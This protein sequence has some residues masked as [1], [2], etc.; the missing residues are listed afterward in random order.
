MTTVP[1]NVCWSNIRNEWTSISSPIAP[2]SISLLVP[3][4]TPLLVSPELYVILDAV[5]LA[6]G[7]G[8]TL[9]PLY[10]SRISVRT[11]TIPND[12][13]FSWYA[14]LLRGNGKWDS[15][16]LLI[17]WSLYLLKP[18][19]CFQYIMNQEICGTRKKISV[20]PISQLL[21]KSNK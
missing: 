13:E 6:E 10:G 4:S 5:V 7:R 18:R 19:T 9:L 21:A 11:D 20:I 3:V 12:W 2:P 14:I 15:V 1:S 16:I 8:T 17:F